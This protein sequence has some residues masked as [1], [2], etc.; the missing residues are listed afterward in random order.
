[1]LLLDHHGHFSVTQSEVLHSNNNNPWSHI[2]TEQRCSYIFSNHYSAPWR[3][4]TFLSVFFDASQGASGMLLSRSQPSYTSHTSPVGFK[5][6]LFWS[7]PFSLLPPCVTHRKGFLRLQKFSGSL[8]R[9]EDKVSFCG[10]GSDEKKG[11]FRRLSNGGDACPAQM[12]LDLS[13]KNRENGWGLAKINRAAYVNP[14]VITG[15]GLLSA[16][17]GEWP[18]GKRFSH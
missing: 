5:N 9:L 14:K 11:D 17:Q 16:I 10:A 1:M 18:F 13:R 4:K 6:S 2:L 15:H 12:T 7:F 3:S 8:C